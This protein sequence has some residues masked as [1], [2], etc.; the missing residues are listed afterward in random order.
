MTRLYTFAAAGALAACIGA[1]AW[2]QTAQS[3]GAAA[4]WA[5][6]VLRLRPAARAYLVPQ[7]RQARQGKPAQTLGLQVRPEQ[8]G[9]PAPKLRIRATFQA[10]SSSSR[11]RQ[12]EMILTSMI[13]SDAHFLRTLAH[14]SS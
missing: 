8:P 4:L 5:A 3:G 9:K 10:G 1:T 13:R 2:S 14:G 12:R 7:V 6:Q 11:H